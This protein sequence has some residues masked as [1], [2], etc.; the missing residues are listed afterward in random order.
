MQ[1]SLKQLEALYWTGKL[2]SFQAAARHL[3]ATQSAI[4]KRITE[5]QGVFGLRLVDSSN[6]RARLTDHG[7]RLLASAEEVLSASRRM[8]EAMG[9]PS[10]FS[11][12]LRLGVSE[13]VAVTWLPLFIQKL[14]EFHPNAVVELDVAP[15]GL[16]LQRLRN[17]ELDLVFVAGPNWGPDLESMPLE[18]VEFAWMASPRLGLPSHAMRADELSAYPMLVH[19]RHGAV[20]QIFARWQRQVGLAGQRVLTANSL[21]VMV[22]LTIGGLGV[23][24]LPAAYAARYVAAGRLVRVRTNPGLPTLK[25]YAVYRSLEDFPFLKEAIPLA[26]SVCDFGHDAGAA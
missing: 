20:S 10:G 8:M 18:D 5:L 1:P 14:K 2:G 4:A 11:G 24:S 19:S 17:S 6:G 26:Q 21:M 13:L 15:G 9:Q 16:I 7:Q 3:H 22:Q 12:V 25:Y 23:S